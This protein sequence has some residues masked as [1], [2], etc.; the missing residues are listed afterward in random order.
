M[1]DAGVCVQVMPGR[2]VLIANHENIT[3]GRYMGEERNML[4]CNV[5]FR[6][7]GAAVMLTN[8]PALALAVLS[9]ASME[10]C[11]SGSAAA[12]PR[13]ACR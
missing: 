6:M 12:V 3:R 4:I 7:G 2:R 9:H 5:L 13:H 8:R 10:A 11:F 1:E